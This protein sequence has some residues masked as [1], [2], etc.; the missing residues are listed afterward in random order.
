MTTS[1]TTSA[2]IASAPGGQWRDGALCAQ[3]DPEIFFPEKGTP[4]RAALRVCAGC[5]VRAACLADALARRDV[6]FGVLGGLTPRQ[7]RELLREHAT[8]SGAAPVS[9]CWAATDV[10]D[11]GTFRPRPYL[12]SGAAGGLPRVGAA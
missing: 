5:P 10:P 2:A 9:T 1:L 8:D 12:P 6:T 3:T 11:P 7:R 4:A